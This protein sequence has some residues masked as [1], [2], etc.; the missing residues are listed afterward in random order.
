MSSSNYV[1]EHCQQ[2]FGGCTALL[3]GRWAQRVE[4]D[5]GRDELIALRAMPTKPGGVEQSSQPARFGDGLCLVSLH[6]TFSAFRS[7]WPA[8]AP[9]TILAMIGQ[10]QRRRDR[11][12]HAVRHLCHEIWK[13]KT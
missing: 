13:Y 12:M 10:I 2:R 8:G 3:I 4:R 9:M 1:R 5:D 6:S 11:L 7:C